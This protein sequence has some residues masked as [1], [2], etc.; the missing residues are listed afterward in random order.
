MAFMDLY[1]TQKGAL[2]V[3]DAGNRAVRRVDLAGADHL[4]TTIAGGGTPSGAGY[5]D[6]DGLA[7]QFGVVFGHQTAA[8]GL[9]G[10]GA[11]ARTWVAPG[12]WVSID[13]T[14]TRVS[15]YMQVPDPS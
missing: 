9:Q 13:T 2:Y 11:C 8:F 10:C 3:A 5:L 12:T 1:H 14:G 7:A 15:Q 6:G 4:V